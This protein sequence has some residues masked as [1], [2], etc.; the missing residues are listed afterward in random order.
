MIESYRKIIIFY[1]SQSIF[2]L[3][4]LRHFSRRFYEIQA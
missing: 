1:A 4:T 2:T 3:Q